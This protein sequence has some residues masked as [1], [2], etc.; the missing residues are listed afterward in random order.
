MAPRGGARSRSQLKT[1]PVRPPPPPPPYTFRFND[2]R[3]Y[4]ARHWRAYCWV[5]LFWPSLW[6]SL[7]NWISCGVGW[8]GGALCDDG[9]NWCRTGV[10]PVRARIEVE[11]I[12]STFRGNRPRTLLNW[13][14]RVSQRGDWWLLLT[15]RLIDVLFD[16]NSLNSS[17]IQSFECHYHWIAAE[18]D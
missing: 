10:G 3:A 1:P 11:T 8:G 2:R 18:I 16:L 4:C 12:G 7:F 13:C 15:L 17:L 5:S 9:E 6:P 14:R